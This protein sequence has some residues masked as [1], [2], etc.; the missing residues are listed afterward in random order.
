MNTEQIYYSRLK[1]LQQQLDR[2]K[3]KRK[4]LGWLRLITFLGAILIF[5][6]FLEI[7]IL[8]AT[9]V[10]LVLLI[11]FLRITLMDISNLKKLQFVTQLIQINEEEISS[12]NGDFDKLE[13]GGIFK[14]PEHP[15]SGDLDIFGR[16]SLFQMVNRTTT[17]LSAK[18]LADWLK[19]PASQAIISE[20]QNAVKMLAPEM[21]WRQELQAV[22]RHKNIHRSDFQ[23]IKIWAE[24]NPSAEPV[25]KWTFITTGALLLTT[26]F[27]TLAAVGV[28]SWQVLWISLI[29][30]AGVTWR[31]G[32]IIGP[33]YQLLSRTLPAMEAF[34]QRLF[35][36]T[37][38]DFGDT[39]L[40]NLKEKC[41]IGEQPASRSIQKLKS[42]LG[43]LD[44]RNNPL[45][46]FPLNLVFFW[47]WHQYRQL[48]NLHRQVHDKIPVWIAVFSEMEALCSFANLA[49]NNPGWSFP[50]VKDT[51]FTF[52]CQEMGHP[53]IQER[54]R[55]CNDAVL[56]GKGRMMLITGSNMAG[57][58]TFLR[59]V[60]VNIVLAM[61]GAPVCA[62]YMSVSVV[63]LISSM[64]IADNLEENISTFYAELKKLERIIVRAKQHDN[65]LLL[66]DEILRGTNSND[67]HTG[68]RA[69]IRQLLQDQAVGILATHDLALTNMAE[70]YPERIMNYHFDV[71]VKEEELFFDYKLKAGICTSMNASLLMRKIG[72]D[73]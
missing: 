45:V 25:R 50:K 33:H 16:H 47:D 60:G 31:L 10:A 36:I 29:V 63:K 5:F 59:T 34:G 26:L 42:I 72:I 46:H 54:K 38:K 65:T 49:F 73:V 1:E 2:Y 56:N 15:Y 41:Y 64:R 7:N 32:K 44:I 6:I 18:L 55:V 21:K 58:S 19:A 28:W 61:A 4:R 35:M 11:L 37:T 14:D 8:G 13:E 68:S 48:R 27:V 30:H 66:L 53:L 17:T 69:L 9:A 52:E 12:L 24:S 57:K 51:Y 43:R 40:Q 62:K 70:Q 71:Q 23:Q 67:R 3:K 22:G 39:R 20:R